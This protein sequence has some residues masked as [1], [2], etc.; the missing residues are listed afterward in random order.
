[1]IKFTVDEYYQTDQGELALCVGTHKDSLYEDY[2]GVQFRIG[3]KN[4]TTI[5]TDETGKAK[6]G[7]VF[8]KKLGAGWKPCPR[9]HVPMRVR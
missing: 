2:C 1:M 5:F 7:N 8:I 6:K 9:C 4:Y 3:H